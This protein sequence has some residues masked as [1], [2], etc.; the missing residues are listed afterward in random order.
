M[1]ITGQA[2]TS[3]LRGSAVCTQTGDSSLRSK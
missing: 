3:E 2:N 1:T